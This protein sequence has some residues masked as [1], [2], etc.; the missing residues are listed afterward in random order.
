M[1]MFNDMSE[2]Q[3][4]SSGEEFFRD[5]IHDLC[6]LVDQE[7]VFFLSDFINRG[8]SKIP[9]ECLPLNKNFFFR[10][11]VGNAFL[12]VFIRAENEPHTK[13]RPD[14]NK[15]NQNSKPHRS[16]FPYFPFRAAVRRFF[17]DEKYQK[18]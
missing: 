11:S 2:F 3:D 13:K 7:P 5:H 6:I 17:H 14:D 9:V 16:R 1:I 15:Q 8:P 18:D 4:L 10:K 12:D